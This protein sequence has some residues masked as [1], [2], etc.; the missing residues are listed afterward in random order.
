MTE[1]CV[2]QQHDQEQSE[3]YGYD[4]VHEIPTGDVGRRKDTAH[5]DHGGRGTGAAAVEPDGD[6]GYDEAHD[7]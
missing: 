7:L 6:Y 4:L 5:H 2:M 1:A 3:D